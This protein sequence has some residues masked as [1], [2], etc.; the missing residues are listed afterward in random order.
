MQIK[1]IIAEMQKH[2]LNQTD[3]CRDLGFSNGDL[4]NYLKSK[5]TLPSSRAKAFEWYFKC[6]NSKIQI[7][8]FGYFWDNEDIEVIFSK[9]IKTNSSLFKYESFNGISYQNFSIEPPFHLFS[10]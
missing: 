1:E 4:S 9:L 8:D 6:K 3:I 10:K 2:G 5:K 7:N